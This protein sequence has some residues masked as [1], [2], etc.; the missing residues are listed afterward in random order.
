MLALDISYIDDTVLY[1][2]FLKYCCTILLVFDLVLPLFGQMLVFRSR[3]TG[4]RSNLFAVRSYTQL[5]QTEKEL[6]YLS[7][8]YDLYTAVLET[9]GRPSPCPNG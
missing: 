7:Q 3:F 1:I 9:I 2:N 4:F 5:D 8:L 6:D